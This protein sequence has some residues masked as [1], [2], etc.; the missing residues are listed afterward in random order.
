MNAMYTLCLTVCE[1]FTKFVL[2][3]VI[4][5]NRHLLMLDFSFPFI[6]CTASCKYEY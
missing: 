3:P 2:F 1:L 4:S 5:Y 6:V